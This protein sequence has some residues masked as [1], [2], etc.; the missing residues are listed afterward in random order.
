MEETAR[1]LEVSERTVKRE[2]AVAA[3]CHQQERAFTDGRRVARGVFGRI[4]RRNEP[5]ILNR[6]YGTALAWDGR[7]ATLEDQV[8]RAVSGHTD[9]GLSVAVAAERLSHD[10]TYTAAFDAAFAAP[11][12]GDLLVQAIATALSLDVPK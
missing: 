10:A 1:T 3:S 6:A 4:G 12:S 8:R 2:W 9:L 11:V 7:A 5:W